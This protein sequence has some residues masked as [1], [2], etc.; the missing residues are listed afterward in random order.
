[1]SNV[2]DFI[3]DFIQK[4]YTFPAGADI[5]KIDYRAEGY[6]DSMGMIMFIASIEDEF[7]VEF[8]DDDM[9]RP[10]INTV[11]GIISITEEKIK[12]L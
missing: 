5:M 8:N 10:E 11:G 2:K 12:T 4:E 9:I 6:I 3:I 7:G 1:M